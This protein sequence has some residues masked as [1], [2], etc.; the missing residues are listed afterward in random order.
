M[1]LELLA[2]DIASQYIGD[3]RCRISEPDTVQQ[4]LEAINDGNYVE[5]AAELTGI[6][7]QTWY[8]WR[9]RGETGEQPFAALLDAVKRAEAR[10][11][12]SEVAKVRTAGNDPRFWAASMTYLERRHPD[13][14]A[15]RT[16]DGNSPKVLVQ[17]GVADAEVKV[18]I[19]STSS[20]PSSLETG[21]EPTR[22]TER[23]LSDAQE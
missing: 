10:S 22:L 5:T 1:N 15:R 23:C 7:K 13:R 4:F 21:T 20:T 11:E 8:T 2:T 3:P 16:D 6:S 12:A 9:K 14:W 17:I 19:A 18:L